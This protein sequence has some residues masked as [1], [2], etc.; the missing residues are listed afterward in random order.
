MS[1]YRRLL[2]HGILGGRGGLVLAGGLVFAG[3][4]PGALGA[5]G[6]VGSGGSA[7]GVQG[8]AP[9]MGPG[10]PGTALITGSDASAFDPAVFQGLRYRMIGPSRGGRVT[11]VAGHRAQPSTFYFGSTGGGVWKS[12]DYGVTWRNIS[13]GYFRTG[14]IGA[15][16]VAESD[17]N[18]IYVGTGS[19]GIRSN[20]IIGKGVYRSTDGGETWAH[21]GLE[22][23]GQIGRMIVHPT[24][25]DIVFVAAIG[26]PFGKGPHRGVYR[27]RDGGRTWEKVLF[28][29]D[30]VGFYGLVMEPGNPNV[31]YASAWRAE[32]KPWTIISGARPE[33]GVGIYKTT[34]GGETW[35]R[36]TNGLPKTMLGK[37]DL[38]ISPANP[39][40]VYALVEAPDPEEGLYRSDDAGQTWHL[41]SNQPGLMNRPFYYTNVHAD[42]KSADVVYVNNESFY[43]STDGGKTWQ[44]LSTPHGDNHDMWINPDNPEIFIQ[45]NDGGA[46]V[47]LDG[48]KTWSTQHNQPTAELYQV[49]VNDDFPSW[50]C[51]GQQDNSTICVPILPPTSSP[52]DA[53]LVWW[54]QVSGCET[55]P[56]VPKP[57]DPDI[58]YG[59]CKGR[60]SRYNHRTGQEQNY[61][62]GAANIYGHAPRDMKYRFQRVAPIE[63]SPHDP[64]VIYHGSQYVHRTTDEGKTWETISPDLTANDPRYQSPSGAPITRDITGEENYSTLYDIEESPV[65]RG[66]IWVGANDGPFHVT[67]DGGRTWTNVTPADLPPGGRVQNI[68]ASPHRGGKA[69][70]AVYRYL[71]DDWQP[72]VYRTTDYGKTWV[73]L[74]DGRNGIPADCPTR[75]VREDPERE[76]LLYA[77]TE[78]GIFVSFDDGGSWQSLQLNFPATPVTDI[79]VHRGDL[80][81]ATMGRSFWVLD[82]VSPLRQLTEQV[83]SSPAHLFAPREAVRMRYRTF[84]SGRS[85]GRPADPQY[86]PPGA[87]L[88]YWLGEEPAGEVKLEILDTA[89]NVI[90]QFTAEAAGAAGGRGAAGPSMPGPGMPL[91]SDSRLERGRGL[92]RFI[93]DLRYSGPWSPSGRRGFGDAGP[94]VVPGEYQVR[95]TVGAWSQTQPLSV[96]MDP[97]IAADGV[98]LADLQA[99]QDLSLKIRDAMSDARRAAERIRAARERLA[100][101]EGAA[102]RRGQNTG[103]KLAALEARLV[104][105]PNVSSYPQPMLIDQLSYLYGM[106]DNADQ[107]PGRDAYERYAEL[108]KELDGILT[109]LRSTLGTDLSGSP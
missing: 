81:I 44:R 65:E 16:R 35:T 107:K 79:Q 108:R 104:T 100:K 20:V 31:L 75:V 17:P 26:N 38:S 59:N 34:D 93:W 24:N 18:I 36:L 67:R 1:A 95:L 42:P 21:V 56:A 14:S 84:Q 54:R 109:E 15:I 60:F 2:S 80:V 106:L 105:D 40:R 89:G 30:S 27:T 6:A 101:G 8:V 3:L 10:A 28:V 88:Y 37:I 83:V 29:S 41:V 69:Y 92:H 55:G 46:N 11:A 12:E 7:A 33:A 90:R 97:R 76:G 39:R 74:T 85:G 45:S 78:C 103:K 98:T 49:D 51:A 50:A 25:P 57:G 64:S 71:L 77:G 53:P 99:Q 52:P 47:T 82:D 73:R 19:D 32:R 91:A 94:M 96:K 58:V 9:G 62:V 61:Y 13:D 102:A 68:E 86:L 23:V 43:R 70:Y 22:S 63:I 48:G 66:V 5:Q 72:Y 4:G 87:V